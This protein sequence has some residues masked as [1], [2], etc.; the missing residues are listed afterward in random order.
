MENGYYIPHTVQKMIAT[1]F[2]RQKNNLNLQSSVLAFMAATSIAQQRVLGNGDYDVSMKLVK[3]QLKP[4]LSRFQKKIKLGT[5]IQQSV[6][7][8]I[9]I[10]MK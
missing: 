1:S 2:H 9:P 3:F 10:Q 8:L 6:K 7:H 4:G 5:R